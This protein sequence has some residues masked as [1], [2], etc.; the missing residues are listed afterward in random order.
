MGLGENFA[1]LDMSYCLSSIVPSLTL[2]YVVDIFGM[3]H[4]YVL[5]G[6]VFGL[7]SAVGATKLIY[8]ADEM[9][10]RTKPLTEI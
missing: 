6:G 1:I 2:G 8:K 5:I 10:P 4:L 7:I 9:P 3:P